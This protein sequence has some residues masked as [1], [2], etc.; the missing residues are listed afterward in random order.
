MFF[1]SLVGLNPKDP[2]QTLAEFD[3]RSVFDIHPGFVVSMSDGTTTKTLM[4][5]NLSFTNVDINSD[6]V[7]GVAAPNVRVNVWAC[8]WANCYNRHAIT[9]GDGNWSVDFSQPGSEGNEQVIFNIVN[10]TWIDSNQSD[11]DGDFTM[12]GINIYLIY[13]PLVVHN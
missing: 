13:L 8:D 2:N 7:S 3:L 12:F 11:A 6:L 9:D 1:D 5:S 4:V 10:G